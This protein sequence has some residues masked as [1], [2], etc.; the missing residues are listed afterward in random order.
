MSVTRLREIIWIVSCLLTA[1]LGW[2]VRE[3]V[4]VAKSGGSI[5]DTEEVTRTLQDVDDFSGPKQSL[6]DTQLIRK[7]FWD[8]DWS[9]KPAPVVVETPKAEPVV[10]GPVYTPVQEIL[11]VYFMQEDVT[12]PGFSRTFV[13]YTAGSGVTGEA[14]ELGQ[15]L[16]PGDS[17]GQPLNELRPC[18]LAD[19]HGNIWVHSIT[20]EKGVTFSFEDESRENESLKTEEFQTDLVIPKVDADSAIRPGVISIP[21]GQRGVAWRPEQTT[22]I[23]SDTYQ[24]GSQDAVDLGENYAH[25]LANEVRHRRHRDPQTG[26]FD[27]IEIQSVTSGSIASRHGAAEGDVIRSINGHPVTSVSEAITFVKNHEDEYSVWEVIISNRGVDR[28]VTYHSSS[29]G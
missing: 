13:F 20:L 27:G 16:Y 18:R 15:V 22:Q 17:D 26:K 1:G 5:I 8:F 14:A 21:M 9:G 3:I 7:T 11:S 2:Y 23:G 19:P 10:N 29:D 25:Y 4:V 12:Q 24:I 6:V 28:T